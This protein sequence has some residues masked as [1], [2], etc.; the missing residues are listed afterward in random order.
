ML[1]EFQTAEAR[2][3][4]I[5]RAWN[6]EYPGL[7][8]DGG[9]DRPG[10]EAVIDRDV[11]GQGIENSFL[12]FDCQNRPPSCHC[13]GPLDRMDADIGAAIDRD[14]AVAKMLTPHP[15]QACDQ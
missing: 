14:D 11:P 13:L 12:R 15:E 8:A 1:L 9:M 2:R 7:R 3:S 5:I 6:L 4:Q 10:I